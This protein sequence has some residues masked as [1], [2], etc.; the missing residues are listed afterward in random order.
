MKRLMSLL[1]I[2]LISTNVGCT[3]CSNCDDYSYGAF[4]GLWQRS[5][6]TYGRVGTAFSPEGFSISEGE[7]VD[8]V[9]LDA[10]EDLAPPPGPVAPP[11]DDDEAPSFD[12]EESSLLDT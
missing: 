10:P 12:D 7:S 8:A 9:E 1:A 5:D 6:L 11:A 3:L 2:V 4:G